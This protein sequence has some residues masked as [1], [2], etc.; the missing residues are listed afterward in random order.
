MSE[1][2]SGAKIDFRTLSEEEQ[3]RRLEEHFENIATKCYGPPEERARKN[4]QHVDD[5]ITTHGEPVVRTLL[6][7]LSEIKE[8]VEPVFAGILRRHSL[9]HDD[10]HD[11]IRFHDLTGPRIEIR[12]HN[13]NEYHLLI[14][15]GW[16][17]ASENWS[18]IIW[19]LGSR[20]SVKC[21]SYSIS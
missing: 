6:K 9:D 17:L 4:R 13:G 14:S 10:L 12:C 18:V 7:V 1:Q 11:I 15:G 16:G 3:I 5:M 21:S 8:P 20:W 2:N 19:R